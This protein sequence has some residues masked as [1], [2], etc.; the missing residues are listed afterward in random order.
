[1]H[2][3]FFTIV[4]TRPGQH[5]QGA[6]AANSLLQWRTSAANSSSDGADGA[7]GSAGEPVG[8]PGVDHLD[9]E[10][11]PAAAHPGAAAAV[12]GRDPYAA[13]DIGSGTPEGEEAAV[14][15]DEDEASVR[16]E[17]KDSGRRAAVQNSAGQSHTE[18]MHTYS[19]LHDHGSLIDAATA[20]V[21]EAIQASCI[22][23]WGCCESGNRAVVLPQEG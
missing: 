1:M 16:Q 9:E 10:S 11:Q 23:V 7:H 22:E 15:A 8:T 4:R 20:N 18:V 14:G 5:L 19:L 6:P 21:T 2:I 13:A 17:E 3:P 12:T